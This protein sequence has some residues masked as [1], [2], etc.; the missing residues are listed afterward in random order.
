[1]GALD[2]KVAIVTGAATGIGRATARLFAQ[3][4]ARL[5]LADVRGDEL[6][7]TVA[8]VRAAGGDALAQTADLARPV[9]CAAVGAAA[10]RA[11]GRLDVVFNHSGGGTLGVGG[12][13]DT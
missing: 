3:A 10:V 5:V 4:G 12:R 7:R 13:C 11:A 1:M 6:E 9:D 2:G 8:E